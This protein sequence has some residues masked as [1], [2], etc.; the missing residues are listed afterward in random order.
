MESHDVLRKVFEQVSPKAIA[1]EM[2]ISLSLVYKWAE[3]PT[4]D[5]GGSRNPLERVATLM[6]LSQDPS[7]IEWLCQQAG[8]CFVR[9]PESSCKSGFEVLPAT[10]EIISQFSQMLQMISLAALDNSISQKEAS[11]IRD[12]W[13]K[14]K[15]YAEGFVRCCE[16][17]DFDQMRRLPKPD[18]T[19]KINTH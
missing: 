12:S 14:L 9:N 8:G 18:F 6:A 2:S 4:T 16:E 13:D 1:A 5:G 11:E 17:G 10:H 15:S 7:I 3:K 19:K